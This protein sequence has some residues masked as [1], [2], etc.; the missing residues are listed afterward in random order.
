MD[1]KGYIPVSRRIFEHPFWCEDREYSRF[2]AWLDLLQTAGFENRKQY[3]GY[4]V[5][6][7]KR[8]QQVAAVRSLAVRWRW[9]KHKVELFLKHLRDEGMITQGTDKGTGIT[10]ITISKYDT[11]NPNP[12]NRGTY[13][14]TTGGQQGDTEG[15]YIKKENNITTLSGSMCET[16]QRKRLKKGDCKG[17]ESKSPGRQHD[18]KDTDP[19]TDWRD[20]F[21]IYLA[22]LRRAFSDLVSDSRWMAQQQELNPSVDVRKSLEKACLNFWATREGWLR[23]KAGK[24]TETINWKLTLANAISQ[25]FNRVYHDRKN[26]SD[27]GYRAAREAEK[28]AGREEL[29]NLA[30]AVLSG[31]AGKAGR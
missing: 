3:V 9:G 7:L 5:V 15:T 29:G 21:E 18:P 8:G 23:K 12:S 13:E 10:I 26:D 28:R 22:D 2:E 20:D 27:N 31:F 14:G 17:E 30:A 16:P 4:K 1:A 25:P 11:Y 19:R 24:R 6:S